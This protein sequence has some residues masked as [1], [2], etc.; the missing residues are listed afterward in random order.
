MP[1]TLGVMAAVTKVLSDTGLN[2]DKLV[3]KDK[4]N[5]FYDVVVFT[6][7]AEGSRVEEQLTKALEEVG[8]R[9]VT[10]LPILSS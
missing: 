5:D 3:T 2:I 6:S 4:V 10:L 7:K 9:L 1:D 8:V